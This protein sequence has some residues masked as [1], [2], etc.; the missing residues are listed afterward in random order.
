MVI[1]LLKPEVSQMSRINWTVSPS[2]AQVSAATI[3]TFGAEAG[4]FGP[5]NGGYAVSGPWAAIYR[6][7]YERALAATAPS[8]FQRMMEPCWN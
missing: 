4:G 6:L 8:R 3:P 2:A 7:A 1:D 5:A